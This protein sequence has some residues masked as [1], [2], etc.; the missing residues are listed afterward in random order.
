VKIGSPKVL[1]ELGKRD[2]LRAPPDA[3]ACGQ[4][5]AASGDSAILVELD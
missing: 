2:V 1:K 3:G 4:Q 5:E